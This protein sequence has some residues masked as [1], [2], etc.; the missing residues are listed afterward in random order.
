DRGGRVHRRQLL[1]GQHGHEETAAGTAVSL[2]NLDPHETELEA[3][4]DEGGV[5]LRRLLHRAHARADLACGEVAH[6]ALKQPFFYGELGER[7]HAFLSDGP[8]ASISRIP[9]SDPSTPVAS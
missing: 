8:G 9:P 3:L 4:R 6:G 7:V 2:R 5:E 1:D